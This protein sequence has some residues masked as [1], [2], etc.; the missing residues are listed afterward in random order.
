[1]SQAIGRI[2]RRHALLVLVFLGTL[3]LGGTAS[4]AAQE[5][6]PAFGTLRGTA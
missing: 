5:E 3:F 6:T 1:M 2:M 4:T